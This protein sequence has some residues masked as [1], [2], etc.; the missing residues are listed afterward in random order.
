MAAIERAGSRLLATVDEILDYARIEA[1]AVPIH[2]ETVRLAT[3]IEQVARSAAPAAIAKGIGLSCD[4]DAPDVTVR[5]DRRCL[6]VALGKL[7]ENA[8][9]FTLRGAVEIKLRREGPSARIEIRDSGIGIARDY[10]PRLFEPFS[11]ERDN[12]ARPFEGIGLGLT[13]ARQFLASNN[14]QISVE[15][16][17]GRGSAF[18]IILPNA[19]SP[20]RH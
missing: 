10:L 19:A 3:M 4:V 7:I 13:I 12:Y 11:Q 2:I 20:V 15:S 17:T 8:I 5:S 18:T 16:E 6:M 1:G 9:K 14:A